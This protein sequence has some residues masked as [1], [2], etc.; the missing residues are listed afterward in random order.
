M[1]Q[2]YVADARHIWQ[3][4]VPRRGNV[5]WDTSYE[6]LLAFVRQTSVESGLFSGEVATGLMSDLDRLATFESPATGDEVFDRLTHRVVD[7]CREHPEP[8]ARVHDPL[9]QR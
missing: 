6:R 9:V 4:Y 7:W 5:N 1:D 8:V 2:Q 3:S